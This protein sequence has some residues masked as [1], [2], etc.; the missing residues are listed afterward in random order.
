MSTVPFPAR[1]QR[2]IGRRSL[3]A[4]AGAA[5]V[6]GFARPAPLWANLLADV[7]KPKAPSEPE[8]LV[9]TLFDTLSEKQRKLMCFDWDFRH[10]KRGLLRTRIENNWHIT[11]QTI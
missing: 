7:A 10:P 2:S 6:G 4:A 5:V 8:P 9:K 1:P 3:L 11:T